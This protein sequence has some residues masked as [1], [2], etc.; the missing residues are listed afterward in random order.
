MSQ[1]KKEKSGEEP[2]VNIDYDNIDVARIMDGIKKKIARRPGR[3]PGLPSESPPDL[4]SSSRPDPDAGRS[5]TPQGQRPRMKKLLLKIMSPFSPLIKLLILPVYEEQR[6]LFLALHNTNIRLDQLISKKETELE[7]LREYTKLLHNISHN[8]VV[9]LSKL[10]IEEE[11]LKTKTQIL[12]KDFE[13]MG[14]RERAVEKE[15]FK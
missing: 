13:F 1:E 9:E 8:L 5:E 14:K 15:V 10:K 3:E 4:D 2:A 12:E 6:Q 7:R 11:M